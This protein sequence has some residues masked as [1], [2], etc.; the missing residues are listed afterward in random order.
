MIF[1]CDSNGKFLDMEK[2]FSANQEVKYIRTP[3]IEHARSY[4]Q[5]QTHTA[6]Q[7]LILHTGTND[8]E[9]TSSPEDLISNILILIT[10]A[11][12]KF[13]SSKIFYSTLLPRSDIPI[14]VI[15]SINNQ[16]ISSCSRLPNVQLV[17][18]DM[19]PLCES[20]KYSLRSETYS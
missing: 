19:Q 18:H 2:M 7:I 6:P 14:P 1:L 12:T 5:S 16:L 17:K 13:P 8:L 9:R 15:T 4:L 11:S 10:E 3:L 20:T